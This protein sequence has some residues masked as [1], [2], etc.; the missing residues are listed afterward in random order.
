[1]KILITGGCGFIGANLAFQ[2]KQLGGYEL[3]IIDNETLGKREYVE[4]SGAKV[5]IGDIRD[6]DLLVKLM[7]GV[8]AVVHL[9]ADTRVMDSIEDPQFNFDVN[10]VGT[11]NI[12]TAMREAGVKRIINASTGG[13]ILGEVEPPVNEDMLPNP[14]SPYGAAKLCAEG[15]LSAFTGSYGFNAVSLRFSNVYGP[16]SYHKGSVV[17]EFFKRILNGEELIV[18]GDGEQTRD[19]VYI[20]DLCDGIVQGLTRDVSGPYQLGTGRGISIN[21][22]ID[23]MREVAG[24]DYKVLTRHEPDRA[25]EILRSYCDIS[26]AQKTLGYDPKMV[27]EQGL[28]ETWDWFKTTHSTS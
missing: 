14:L 7:D 2:L 16:R 28:S 9:A 24:A 21:Q 10:V 18:Y 13:A 6:K 8:D 15:Y 23:M 5:H 17:A 20:D 19:Y 4:G 12:L 26:K 1:M 25:G 22:L 3:V 11:F 27:L